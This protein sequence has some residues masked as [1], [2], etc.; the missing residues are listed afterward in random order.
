MK[1]HQH[2]AGHM[3]EMAVIFISGKKTLKIFFPGTT[4][5]ILMTFYMKH[6]KPNPYIFCSNYDPGL[7]LTY[8]WQCQIYNLV[9]YM[10]KSDSDGFFGHYCIR[11]PVIRILL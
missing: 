2:N 9:F 1:I 10:E 4:G 6:Q 7:T 8:L 11:L 5:L 3:T